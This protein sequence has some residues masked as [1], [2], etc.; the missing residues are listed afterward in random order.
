MNEVRENGEVI[1]RNTGNPEATEEMKEGSIGAELNPSHHRGNMQHVGDK[2][3]HVEF[4]S[5]QSCQNV[6]YLSRVQDISIPPDLPAAAMDPRDTT[7]QE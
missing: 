6:Q 4:K 2:K 7:T 3:K 5:Y 1:Q